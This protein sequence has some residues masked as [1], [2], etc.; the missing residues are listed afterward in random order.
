MNNGQY[1]ICNRCGGSGKIPAAGLLRERR[2]KSGKS[3]RSVARTM[4]ISSAYLSDLERGNRK[5][6]N[7]LIEKFHEALQ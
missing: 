6:D 7:E 5:W 4:K 2:E 3:L 1:E